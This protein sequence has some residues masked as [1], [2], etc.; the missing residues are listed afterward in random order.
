MCAATAALDAA[1]AGTDARR[2]ALDQ[3]ESHLGRVKRISAQ[4]EGLQQAAAGL[5]PCL[6]VGGCVMWMNG[7]GVELQIC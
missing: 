3:V 6:Q 2:F 5:V 7:G 4:L 1:R